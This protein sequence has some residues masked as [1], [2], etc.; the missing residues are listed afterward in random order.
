[1]DIL[2]V[3]LGICVVVVF[4]FYVLAQ[5]WQRLLVRHSW[6]VRELTE[7]L[8]TLEEIANPDLLRKVDES[9]SPPLEQVCI[10]RLCF[11][12]RFWNETVRATS[13]EMA[14]VRRQGN[15][16]GSVKIER[17]RSHSVVT[18]AEILPQSKSATWQTRSLEI[19]PSHSPGKSQASV[20]WELSLGTAN[21]GSPPARPRSLELR[22]HD[23]SL[24]LCELH[25]PLLTGET[26]ADPLSEDEAVL[27]SV[28]LDASR[29]SRFRA[30]DEPVESKAFESVSG[31]EEP[32]GRQVSCVSFYE[33]QDESLG[34][35]WQLC[36]RNLGRRDEGERLGIVESREIRKVS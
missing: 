4:V 25:N 17:W 3:A 22:L 24:I 10:F 20:L 34:V 1:V 8:A 14:F 32:S 13:E 36:L 7:R 5:H 18:V 29:L 2:W 9:A 30:R 19:F 31:A 23:D 33:H 27:I 11:S 15:L 21:N 6:T 16:L 28:P 35:D 26:S 12:D